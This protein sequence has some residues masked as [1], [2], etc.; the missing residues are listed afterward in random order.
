[1]PG[2]VEGAAGVHGEPAVLPK[3]VVDPEPDRS[4]VDD[5]VLAEGAVAAQRQPASALLDHAA[6]AVDRAGK[7]GRLCGAQGQV[8]GAELDRAAGNARQ[9]LDRLVLPGARNVE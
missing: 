2:K 6:G 4:I 8:E 3:G 9:V 1:M 5:E 7:D